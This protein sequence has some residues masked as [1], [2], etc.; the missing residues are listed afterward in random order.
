[1]GVNILEDE[2]NRIA[3]LQLN[4]YSVVVS[5]HR[6]PIENKKKPTATF[7]QKICKTL[8]TIHF[9]DFFLYADTGEN[10]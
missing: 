3:L 5:I 6:L 1:M 4:M 9:A 2:R 8:Y 10:L 7:L